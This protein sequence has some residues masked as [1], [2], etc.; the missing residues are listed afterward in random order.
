M[1]GKTKEIQQG[2]LIIPLPNKIYFLIKKTSKTNSPK[3]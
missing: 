1:V 2:N 3:R